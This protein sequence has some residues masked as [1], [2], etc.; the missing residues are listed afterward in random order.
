M[1]FSS[2]ETT[3][4]TLKPNQPFSLIFITGSIK[5]AISSSPQV[6]ISSEMNRLCTLRAVVYIAVPFFGVAH[7]QI[8]QIYKNIA[9]TCSCRIIRAQDGMKLGFFSS[10]EKLTLKFIHFNFHLYVR[11]KDQ[12]IR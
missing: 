4:V 7:N 5:I 10:M 2:P 1:N 12:T 3:V 9:I 8:C 6:V 11:S